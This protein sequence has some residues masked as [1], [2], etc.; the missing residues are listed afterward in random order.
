MV[1][2]TSEKLLRNICTLSL[3]LLYQ[4]LLRKFF[5]IAQYQ[6][7]VLIIQ[8]P[9]YLSLAFTMQLVN[10][11]VM[12]LFLAKQF[13]NSLRLIWFQC[14]F[15]IPFIQEQDLSPNYTG[16]CQHEPQEKSLHPNSHKDSRINFCCKLFLLLSCE[17][18]SLYCAYFY[19][20]YLIWNDCL[21]YYS[22]RNSLESYFS[23]LIPFQVKAFVSEFYSSYSSSLKVM[24]ISQFL[25]NVGFVYFS[26]IFVSVF[27]R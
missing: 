2:E 8:L 3:P 27:Q 21:N 6:F 19:E 17:I 12:I 1:F 26:M 7:K 10:S 23:R 15:S 13:L 25:L 11:L 14:C 4:T 9:F 24:R 5:N 20:R 16:L 18:L 22:L